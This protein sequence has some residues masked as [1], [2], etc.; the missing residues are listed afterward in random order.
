MMGTELNRKRGEKNE[1]RM[2]REQGN[3]CK[4]S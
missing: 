3:A 4:H 1:G 2:G